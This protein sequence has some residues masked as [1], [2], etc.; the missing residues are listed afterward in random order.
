[1]SDTVQTLDGLYMTS[2][3]ICDLFHITPKTVYRWRKAGRLKGQK[4]GRA[5]LYKTSDVL[6]LLEESDHPKTV[7]NSV[8]SE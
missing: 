7:S 8:N 1:M 5:Y 2:N 4:A 6:S 3:Q